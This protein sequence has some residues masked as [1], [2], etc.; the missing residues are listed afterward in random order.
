MNFSAGA[1]LWGALTGNRAIRDLGIFLYTHRRRPSSSTGSTSISRCFPKGSATAR[2]RWSGAAGGKYDTWWDRTRSSSTGST[3]CPSRGGSLYLGRHPDYVR[4]NYEELVRRN[5]GEPLSGATSSGCTWR[6]PIPSARSSSS[7]RPV[8]R[9]R[10]R[11]LDGDDLPLDLEPGG[12]R[13][14]RHRGDG[15]RADLRRVREGKSP[16]HV[17]FNP[18]DQPLKVTFSDGVAHHRAAAANGAGNGP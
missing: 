2:W 3:S 5:K 9:S 18:T 16:T 13:A 11:Q 14:P 8:L 6:W 4:R 12:A 1:I 10:V 15:R 17:A 7:R